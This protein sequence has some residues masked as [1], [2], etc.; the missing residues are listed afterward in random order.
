MKADASAEERAKVFAALADADKRE[1]EAAAAAKEAAA[2][3]AE[4]E[5]DMTDKEADTTEKEPAAVEDAPAKTEKEEATA[6]KALVKTEKDGDAADQQ[7]AGGDDDDGD[8]GAGYVFRKRL[9]RLYNQ[10]CLE[11]L[12]EEELHVKRFPSLAPR[13]WLTNRLA[14]VLRAALAVVPRSRLHRRY[15]Q[16]GADQQGGGLPEEPAPTEAGPACVL[17]LRVVFGVRSLVL[18]Q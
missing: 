2:A 10:D 1:R 15:G 18:R 4:K 3:A 17:G 14:R 7:A 16:A 6:E 13:V 8:A 11:N 5:A 12:D 9:P